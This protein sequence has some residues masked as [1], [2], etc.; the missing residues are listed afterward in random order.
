MTHFNT[1]LFYPEDTGAALACSF[2]LNDVMQGSEKDGTAASV[3]VS[4]SVSGRRNRDGT[5]VWKREPIRNRDLNSEG[6]AREPPAKLLGN[7]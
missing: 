7:R 2:V 4:G 3:S 1:S 6:T 5:A